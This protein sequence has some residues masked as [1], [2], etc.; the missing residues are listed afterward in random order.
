M[1][2]PL[3]RQPL[4]Q[5]VR[6]GFGPWSTGL[7]QRLRDGGF[8]ILSVAAQVE[9]CPLKQQLPH[10][11]GMFFDRVLH[12]VFGGTIAGKRGNEPIQYAILAQ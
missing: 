4:P 12:V 10:V 9:V 5:A 2:T 6:R 8:K 3:L 11:I 1:Q 7:F